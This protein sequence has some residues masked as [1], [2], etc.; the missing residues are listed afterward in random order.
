MMPPQG[1]AAKVPYIYQPILRS[2]TIRLLTLLPGIEGTAIQCELQEVTLAN[3]WPQYCALSYVW[4]DPQVTEGIQVHGR[5][6]Q[7]TTNLESALQRLRLCDDS[8]TLWIDAICIDQENFTERNEQIQLMVQIYSLAANVFVW[9]GNDDS[10]HHA[11]NV[12]EDLYQTCHKEEAEEDG[13]EANEAPAVGMVHQSK[14]SPSAVLEVPNDNPDLERFIQNLSKDDYMNLGLAFND[15]CWWSRA[16]ILQEVYHA[17]E[18]TIFCGRQCISWNVVDTVIEGIAGRDYTL[19]LGSTIGNAIKIFLLKKYKTEFSKDLDSLLQSFGDKCC[20]DPRDHI[21][22]FISLSDGS[23]SIRPDYKKTVSRVYLESTTALIKTYKSLR[24]IYSGYSPEILNVSRTDRRSDEIIPSWVP[25][26]SS[27]RSSVET[28]PFL[29]SYFKASLGRRLPDTLTDT[30]PSEWPWLMRLRGVMFDKIATTFP[31]I[32][33][34]SPGWKSE[35]LA[36]L[37]EILDRVEYPTG[38]AV[39]DAVWTT[40]LKDIARGPIS[41]RSESRLLEGERPQYREL[42]RHWCQQEIDHSNMGGAESDATPA[43][44]QAFNGILAKSLNEYIVFIT[45]RGYIGLTMGPVK[46]DDRLYVVS[47]ATVPLLLRNEGQNFRRWWAPAAVNGWHTLVGASYVHGI[48]DGEVMKMA[49]F[50]EE[51]IFLV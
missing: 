14:P 32:A 21:F 40:L 9:L 34:N 41:K 2:N 23:C 39:F 26:W 28:H 31:R 7:V 4:G 47:G 22:A 36:W 24:K 3:D 10:T 42:F 27:D 1:E 12:L 44:I 48:M 15:N 35:V 29:K 18:I 11:F 6:L 50:K 45:K 8:R 51:R 16:W 13:E 43:D 49:E 17:S 5:E 37:P 19:R 30:F 46:R 20:T 25:D 33:T 38:E